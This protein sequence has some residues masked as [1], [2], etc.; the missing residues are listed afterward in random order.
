M[1]RFMFCL[2]LVLAFGSGTFAQKAEPGREALL[3]G[4][5]EI[6][7]PG[8]PGSVALYAPGAEA[9]VAGKTGG[10]RAVVVATARL[11]RG[12]IVAFGHD[13]YFKEE[14]LEKLDTGR[15]VANAAKWVAGGK[16]KAKVG[17]GR[18]VAMEAFLRDK[19]FL[20]SRAPVAE[21]ARGADVLVIEPGSLGPQDVEA[22]R[23]F[24]ER[25]GGLLAAATGWGWQQGSRLPMAEFAGNKLLAGT[26]LAWSDG[27]VDRTTK[28][29]FSTDGTLPDALNATVALAALKDRKKLAGDDLAVGLSSVMLALRSVPAS[30]SK[31]RAE[32][33]AAVKNLGDVDV[34]PTEKNPATAKD[35]IRRFAIGLQAALAESTPAAEI[36]ALPA[37]ADFPGAVD[38]KAPRVTRKV[39]IDLSI[40]HWHSLGLYAPA[41]GKVVV[42]G[43]ESLGSLKL[44]VQVGCHTDGLW[45]LKKW[46]RLPEVARRF[47]IDGSKTEVASALGGLVYIDVPQN[48]PKEKVELTVEGAVEAP[49][50]RLG[51]TTAVD[52]KTIR[53]RPAPWAELA[54][55]NVIFTVPA[56][57]ARR[58]D[59]PAPLMT[60]WD[61][62]VAMQD[63]LAVSPPRRSPE[64]IVCD[65]Q[66]SAGYMHSGYPIMT[67]IDG[68]AEQAMDLAKLRAE[69]S[70]G[71][72]HELGHNHQKPEWTFNG[73]GEVTNNVLA[74]YVFDRLLKLPYDSGHPAIRDRAKRAEKIRDH[75]AKGAPFDKWKDDP[76]LALS[77]YLQLFEGFGWEP[78]ERVFAEYAKLPRGERPRNDDAKRDQW[79]VRFSRAVGKN[80][81]PFFQAWGVP[82]SQSARDSIKDLPA[83]SPPGMDVKP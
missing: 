37:A 68:S 27:M 45:D 30:E 57:L 13:G 35:P 43:P 31:F 16:A 70:W 33:L 34:I 83:W 81:G 21:A 3:D 11:G 19:G 8:I 22:V 14:A 66:I 12:R 38:P 20:V 25:G 7:A 69:G 54:G 59:D 65:R 49:L 72:F 78:F 52:W 32:V 44:A 40:P 36:V 64:R 58:V 46:E 62:V 5:K 42:T 10:G 67:P 76:F 60:F 53:Q 24:V 17:V 51:E 9:I 55:N 77:M 61:E 15:L 29:G 56:E 50:F 6:T 2:A 71:H 41:G 4:V 79:L 80:L 74:V 75:I 47:P 18:S 28:E 39:A 1:R 23:A 63:A 73:T 48:A 82:T 26:G